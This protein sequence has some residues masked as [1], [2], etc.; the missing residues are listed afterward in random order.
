MSESSEEPAGVDET[1]EC[2]TEAVPEQ[3][4]D[5]AVRRTSEDSEAAEPQV[6]DESDP[7]VSAGT[8]NTR[9]KRKATAPQ[10]RTL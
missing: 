4:Q 7:N 3:N 5:D 1:K 9:W 10:S 8:V 2:T 6:Q